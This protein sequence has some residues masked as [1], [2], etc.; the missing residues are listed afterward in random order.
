VGW[1]GTAKMSEFRCAS[2]TCKQR[3]INASIGIS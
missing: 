1:R 2:D 3:L